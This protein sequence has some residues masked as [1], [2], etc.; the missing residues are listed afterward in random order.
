M[1]SLS[2]IEG[3]PRLVARGEIRQRGGFSDATLCRLVARKLFPAPVIRQPRF[4]CWSSVD[5]DAWF[6]DPARWL[7]GEPHTVTEG[8]RHAAR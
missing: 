6:A 1:D 3:L 5:V 7:S 4:T 2:L 8:S